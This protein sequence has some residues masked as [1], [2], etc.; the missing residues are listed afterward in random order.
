M[1]LNE[2]ENLDK[3]ATLTLLEVQ[4]LL[5]KQKIETAKS[6]GKK[7]ATL[8]YEAFVKGYQETQYILCSEWIEQSKKE[9]EKAKIQREKQLEKLLA[10]GFYAN[11]E[12]L[13]KKLGF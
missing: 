8:E 2:L 10:T 7:I 1:E 6:L 5:L 3:E 9:V 13:R 4:E 12:E 11:P